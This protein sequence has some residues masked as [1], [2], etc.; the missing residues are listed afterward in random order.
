MLP[1][2]RLDTLPSMTSADALYESLGFHEIPPYRYNPVV[3][4]RY[5]ELAL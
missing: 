5:L 1:T 2:L 4:T 3:G